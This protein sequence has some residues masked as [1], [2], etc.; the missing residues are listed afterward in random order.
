MVVQCKLEESNKILAHSEEQEK[1]T[2]VLSVVVYQT[3]LLFEGQEQR[4]KGGV[5]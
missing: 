1:K 3:Y 2:E 4:V 5:G